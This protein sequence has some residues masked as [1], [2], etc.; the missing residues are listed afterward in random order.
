MLIYTPKVGRLL[1]LDAFVDKRE[2]DTYKG[3]LLN[4]VL[5]TSGEQIIQHIIN[6]CS[7]ATPNP[8]MMGTDVSIRAVVM[9]EAELKEALDDAY[10]QGAMRHGR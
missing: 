4:H 5:K 9:S 2:L 1:T 3:R 8:G 7:T 10:K 6:D